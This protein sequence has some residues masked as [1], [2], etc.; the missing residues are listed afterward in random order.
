[1]RKHKRARGRF[2]ARPEV[3]RESG[4][5]GMA[6]GLAIGTVPVFWWPARA[7]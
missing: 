5:A 6:I 7:P 4:I 3:R 2:Q 1:M